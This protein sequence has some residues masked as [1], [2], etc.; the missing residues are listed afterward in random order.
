LK[1]IQN[2]DNNSKIIYNKDDIILENYFKNSKYAI[3]FSIK[4]KMNDFIINGEKIFCAK[5]KELIINQK[6]T[7]L[8]GKHNLSNIVAAIQISKLYNIDIDL[9]KNALIEFK[10][11]KHRMETV[12]SNSNITFIN[13]SKGTN[14]VSTSSAVESFDKNII[15]ILG[16]FSEDKINKSDIEKLIKKNNIYMVVCYGQIGKKIYELIKNIKISYY[17]KS[18][19]SAI[20][21]AIKHSFNNSVVLLSPG[22]KSFDQ[23]NS[24]EERGEKFKEI[25]NHYYA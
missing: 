18:F 23:F 17:K 21:H 14:L 2:L 7:N 13:D 22:F 20:K 25:I 16:G 15:L 5:S 24:F 8:I 4:N 1:I 10:P 19:S 9:I 12:K 11:L 3:S 6:D